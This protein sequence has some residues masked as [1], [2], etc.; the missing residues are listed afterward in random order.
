MPIKK[1]FLLHLEHKELEVLVEQ[2]KGSIYRQ[3]E[4]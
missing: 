4:N 2:A 3:P 1:E